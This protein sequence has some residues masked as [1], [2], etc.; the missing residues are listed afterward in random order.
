MHASELLD[1]FDFDDDQ[2]FHD[3]VR[4]KTFVVS[5]PS[6]LDFHRNLP[7]NRK[8]LVRE[9]IR[10]DHFIHGFEKAGSNLLVNSISRIN[11]STR[12]FIDFHGVRSRFLMALPP[13]HEISSL[14][15]LFSSVLCSPLCEAFSVPDTRERGG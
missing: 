11:D 8:A 12:D 13:T 15:V 2:T 9:P 14:A 5:L 4:T 7:L 1:G 6:D 3:N 10:Q